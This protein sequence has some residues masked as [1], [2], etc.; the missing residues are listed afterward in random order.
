[1]PRIHRVLLMATVVLLGALAPEPAAGLGPTECE[2]L[3]TNGS[4]ESTP[5]PIADGDFAHFSDTG[6]E[7]LAGWVLESGD[8]IEIQRNLNGAAADGDHWLELAASSPTTISQSVSVVPGALYELRFAYSA[9]PFFG[10]DNTF[11]VSWAGVEPTLQSP[12]VSTI[13]WQ[14][15][16]LTAAALTGGTG[17]VRFEDLSGG[18]PAA[19][20]FIDDVTLCR[21]EVC[22][23]EL[24]VPSFLVAQ[25]EPSGTTTLFAVR[26]LTSG[27]VTAEVEYHTVDG[28]SQQLDVLTLGPFETRTVNIRDVAGLPS[29][30]DGFARGFVR[31]RAA[32]GPDGLPVLAG[33]F[34]QVDV[35]NN[36]AT[37]DQL[38]GRSQLCRHASIRSLDFGAGT[39]L[40]VY[41]A[42][43]RGD[44]EDVDPPSFTVQVFDEAG[45]PEAAPQ[46]VW[47]ADHA[48]ELAASDL[49]ANPFGTLVFDFTNGAG[50]AA[51]A[52][53]SA[54]G[55]FS[56]G[57]LSQCEE[58][59]FCEGCCAPGTPKATTPPLHYSEGSVVDGIPIDDC[60][61]AISDSLRSLDSFHYRNACQQAHGGELP[62]RVLGARI[63]SCEVAPPGFNDG[64]VVVIE[65]CCPPADAD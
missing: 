59:P 51:Y 36:F 41:V 13:T 58:A 10:D 32:G 22:S 5:Q 49:T 24:V 9:R 34:F 53:Y 6:A 30:P 4:F 16:S 29:D 15:A 42:H 33:D 47:T 3:L 37:G 43:P 18:N 27:P 48:L 14:Y 19:G 63:V 12:A 20:M 40:A 57:V 44:D 55:R 1:M 38:L 61:A 31:V 52:E 50:G 17:T 21:V 65:A 39:R 64:V 54:Q 60:E 45:S 11:R 46:P 26:N 23:E 62:D 8:A 2:S 56:V 7:D 35:G 25:D 28:A